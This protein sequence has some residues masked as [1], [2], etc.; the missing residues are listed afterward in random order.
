MQWD[1][2]LQIV[3]ETIQKR[4]LLPPQ[5]KVLIAISGGPDS[6]L[7]AYTLHQLG[8]QIGLAHIN[9]NLRGEDSD[10]EERLVKDYGK[11][12]AVPVF[13]QVCDTKAHA[14]V[15]QLTLQVAARNLRY[16]F[17]DQLLAEEDFDYCATGHQA[18]DQM[19]S[20]LMSLLKGNSPAVLKGI[21]VKRGPYIRPFIDL[22]RTQIELCLE[23]LGLEYGLDYTNEENHYLRNQFRNQIIPLLHQINPSI[24]TQLLSRY[25]WYTQQ[26][27]FQQ[28]F[29]AD[30]LQRSLMAENGG[31]RLLFEPFLAAF[32]P[33]Y[34]P[35]LII[36]AGLHWGWHGQP[37]WRLL[38][39]VDSQPGKQIS[40]AQ[41]EVFRT[42]D[43]LFFQAVSVDQPPDPIILQAIP[44]GQSV[45]W[46]GR[47]IHFQYPVTPPFA[48][49]DNVFFLDPQQIQ[50]PLTL[51]SW[52]E[53][54]RMQPYGMQGLKK[55]SD[56]FIDLK[57]SPSKKQQ[58]IV[59]EDV[60]QIVALSDF[61]IAD[62][63]QVRPHTSKVLKI[64]IKGQ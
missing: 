28:A 25:D 52:Q 55:L 22:N 29:L 18:N 60:Q 51:R 61:R 21:P 44:A 10:H 41:G 14:E 19:E 17:F 26:F 39:L 64:V 62:S 36:A 53:R 63:V 27:S 48:F 37:L 42:G 32:S 50:W 1:E 30:W 20:I 35:Q 59:F 54:D 16:R 9:Y 34:L 56:I 45:Q 5:A 57:F 13:V 15:H 3:Q 24:G 8:Y 23:E 33:Q 43:G 7:L 49:A 38:E 4:K 58:A 31:E 2:V 11:A 46:I 6:V 40:S 47:N 12:W